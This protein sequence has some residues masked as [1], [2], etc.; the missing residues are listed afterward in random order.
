MS[1]NCHVFGEIK[2]TNCRFK[3]FVSKKGSKSYEI[4]VMFM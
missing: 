1:N 3:A 4:R 2:G